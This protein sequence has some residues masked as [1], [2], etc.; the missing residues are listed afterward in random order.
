MELL[1]I[2]QVA[3]RIRSNLLIQLELLSIVGI[4]ALFSVQGFDIVPKRRARLRVI[5]REG[6]VFAGHS[7]DAAQPSSFF[8]GITS[9][10]RP[11]DGVIAFLDGEVAVDVCLILR[12]DGLDHTALIAALGMSMLFPVAAK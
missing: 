12:R 2:G 1:G 10:H 9:R 4:V 5:L 7:V 3:N 11:P 8:K 6:D